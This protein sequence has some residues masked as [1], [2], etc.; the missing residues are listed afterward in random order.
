M[1]GYDYI[2]VFAG[3]WKQGTCSHTFPK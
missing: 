1:E 3:W 2:T